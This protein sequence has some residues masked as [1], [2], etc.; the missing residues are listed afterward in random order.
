[1]CS[2]LANGNI[3]TSLLQAAGYVHIA[4]YILTAVHDQAADES[5]TRW[6]MYV[7]AA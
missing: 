2:V 4:G 5:V 6:C 3:N 1:M 7:Q